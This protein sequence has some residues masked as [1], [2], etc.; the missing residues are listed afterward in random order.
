MPLNPHQSMHEML[1]QINSVEVT[2]E[3]L[4]RVAAA[5][6]GGPEEGSEFYALM[7]KVAEECDH[8]LQRAGAVFFRF[9]ALGRLMR[10]HE[11]PGW[12]QPEVTEGRVPVG[13]PLLAAAAEVPVQADDQERAAFDPEAI[14]EAARQYA[15]AEG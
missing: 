15:Q 1:D 10:D 13:G 4:L 9:Q 12:A 3:E 2:K 14:L 8:D 5:L 7:D 11:L 6:E